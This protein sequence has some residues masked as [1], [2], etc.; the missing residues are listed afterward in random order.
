[1]VYISR[2]IK[3]KCLTTL[4]VGII[5]LAAGLVGAVSATEYSVG[6]GPDDWWTVYPDQHPNAGSEVDHPQWILDELEEKPVLILDHSTGKCKACIDQESYV[7][8]VLED[9]GDDVTYENLISGGSDTRAD[10]LFDIYDPN[11]GK[12]YIPL[13][14]ILTLVE[15]SDGNVVVG[16]HSME[17]PA[18]G[19]E[20]VRSYI[21][22]AIDYHE[23][24]VGDWDA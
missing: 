24:N 8:A 16:W 12:P 7:D 21:E 15:D 19:E 14:V 10:E 3:D 22:D 4:V 23:E 2:L 13:T 5:V 6:S 18:G 11:G 1:L 17:D 9:Y 20:M